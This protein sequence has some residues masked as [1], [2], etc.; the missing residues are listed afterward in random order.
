MEP[1]A[2]NDRPESVNINVTTTQFGGDDALQDNQANLEDEGKEPDIP[3]VAGN[4]DLEVNA[5]LVR[6]KTAP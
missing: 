3:V 2:E 1:D 4:E 5:D 6:P